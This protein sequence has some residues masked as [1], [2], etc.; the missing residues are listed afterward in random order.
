MF[1][2]VVQEQVSSLRMLEYI[3]SSLIYCSAQY[4]Q[5][6]YTTRSQIKIESRNFEGFPCNSPIFQS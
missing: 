1:F 6:S 3:P 2:R 4:W 5:L